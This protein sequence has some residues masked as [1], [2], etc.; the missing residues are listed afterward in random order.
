MKN[1]EDRHKQ[2]DNDELTDAELDQKLATMKRLSRGSFV[3][4]PGATTDP[5]KTKIRVT[6]YLDQDVLEYFKGRAAQPN[7]VPY[8]TQINSE[9]RGVMDRDQTPGDLSTT[10]SPAVDCK[11]LI[12]NRAFIRMVAEKVQ[13]YNVENDA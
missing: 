4:E 11:Q 1:K 6:L 12:E 5:R 7:A 13:E 2:P 3:A 9:L 8:Q 10:D